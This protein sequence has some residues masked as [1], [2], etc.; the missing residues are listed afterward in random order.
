[1]SKIKLLTSF[2]IFASSVLIL[3]IGSQTIDPEVLQS[4]LSESADGQQAKGTSY[5]TFTQN[6]YAQTLN[7][8]KELDDEEEKS[9]FYSSLMEK[10]VELVS[11]LCAKDPRACY[12][13]DEYRDMK[14]L[15]VPETIDNLKLFGLDVFTGYPINLDD[16]SEL[17]LPSDY[18]LK[19]G[20]ELKIS[21]FGLKNHQSTSQI[22]PMGELAIPNFGTYKISGLSLKDAKEELLTKIRITYPGSEITLSLSQLQP[23]KVFVLG[24][25]VNPGSYGVNAFATAINA[26]IT[27][28]G[29]Q[30]NSSLR[31]IKINSS[32]KSDQSLDLYSFLIKGETQSDVVL[33]DGD[34]VLVG[35]LE[36]SIKIFGEIIRPAIYEIKDGENVEDI[37]S[38]ALG[39]TEMADKRNVTLQRKT[40]LGSLETIQV[41]EE[42]FSSF[43]VKSGDRIIV[44]PIAGEELNT[45]A[46]SG[47]IRNSGIFQHTPGK[48]LSD[49]IDLEKDL[50]DSTYTLMGVVKRFD[51]RIR[52]WTFL[53][54]DL[55]NPSLLARS[56]VMPRDEIFIFSRDDI[57][58]LNSPNLHDL[59]GLQASFNASGESKADDSPSLLNGGLVSQEAI[60]SALSEDSL[61]LP[62]QTYPE[63]ISA[64]SIDESFTN[65]LNIQ[66][67]AFSRSYGDRPKMSQIICPAIFL[68]EPELIPFLMIN[69]IPVVGN[70]RL[71][72]LYP[73][74]KDVN[75]MEI[76]QFA[77]GPMYGVLK[78]NIFDIVQNKQSL[79]ISYEDLNTTTNIKFLNIRQSLENTKQGYVTL[80]GEFKFPGTYSISDGE[81]IT[82]VF[83]RAGGLT[84]HSYPHGGIL[85]RE[86]VK[87]IEKKVLIKA[88]KDLGEV[89][90]SAAMNGYLDQNPTDLVQLISLI[91]SLS[92][93]DGLG[94]IVAEL[95][96]NKI[97]RDSALDIFVEH[98]DNFYI[99]RINSTITIVG[100]VLNPITVPYNPKLSAKD[101]INLAGGYSKT[102]DKRSS[103]IVFPNGISRKIKNSYFA[104]RQGTNPVPG[105][106]IIIPR[107]ANNLDTMSFLKFATPI[108]AD[109]SVTAASIS[110]ITN[111]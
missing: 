58:F 22:S 101:Y 16:F 105:S 99:P 86:S 109:L 93:S 94:R 107:K 65:M 79:N 92:E 83:Q 42:N 66:L 46:L 40:K 17:P 60:E 19:V 54:F 1:M 57:R 2:I 3:P 63:C 10:R 72:A 33:E 52:G 18:R 70:I 21:I 71:P 6:N 41:S 20:D 82:S 5:E 12:L 61:S 24:N 111:N 90:A 23:K 56:P 103:Y 51:K 34:A 28:G 106:T 39:F 80:H 89:L 4:I 50:L 76:I 91:S 55:L 38:F 102:A 25:V 75:P 78:S 48:T 32:N 30:G 64:V 104:I 15:E 73:V 9:L 95:D 11:Q 59:L 108:L 69:S 62:K 31:N 98:G 14:F 87:E 88:Q 8:L 27:G 100:N 84:K 96:P 68:E 37:L 81:T 74:S 36:K 26:L 45:V 85:T 49:F 35:G 77:G 13:I 44:N 110:A 43:Q 53:K 47:A 7:L 67:S 97:A 29:L